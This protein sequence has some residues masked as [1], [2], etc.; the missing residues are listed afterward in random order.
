MMAVNLVSRVLGMATKGSVG[1]L[2]ADSLVGVSLLRQLK[3]AGFEVHAWSRKSHASD[4][5]CTWHALGV[6][7][8][9]PAALPC[10]IS[11]APLPCL[12]M[13]F[14][15]MQALG[16]TQ[17]VALS[18]TSRYTKINSLDHGDRRWAQDLAEA[19]ERLEHWGTAH[20]VSTTILR[21]TL[22]Y[23]HGRDQN[24]ATI[25]RVLRRFHAFPIVG[26][27][28]G[29]RQP[30]HAD[31]VAQA[32]LAAAERPPSG[33]QAFNL[34]GGETLTYQAMV[35]RIIKDTGIR[36]WIIPVPTYLLRFAIRILR[37]LPAYRLYNPAMA[38]RMMQDLTF[39]HDEATSTLGFNPR[40]FK[41]Q[42]QDLP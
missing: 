11:L 6:T 32:C 13:Y 34:S 27:G 15:L 17:V 12:P 3:T 9:Y 41:L 16:V 31:D 40:N 37:W 7:Q 2:G 10:W 33:H 38:D 24:I 25:I 23:G 4:D 8:G 30:V 18:S 21:P 5:G 36:G 26:G 35:Q 19:E 28:P 39:S 29:L 42:A 20:A 14:P 22:I 1:V